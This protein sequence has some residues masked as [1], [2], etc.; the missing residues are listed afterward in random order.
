MPKEQFGDVRPVDR[1]Y[2]DTVHRAAV[3]IGAD[4]DFHAGI[5][6]IALL[7]PVHRSGD[8]DNHPRLGIG[9]IKGGGYFQ[10]AISAVPLNSI[11]NQSSEESGGILYLKAREP[12]ASTGCCLKKPQFG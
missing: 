7:G 10:A 12:R 9:Q 4:G 5:P 3:D 11:N 1:G 2:P 6:L 8:H